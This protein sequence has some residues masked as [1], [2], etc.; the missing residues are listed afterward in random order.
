MRNNSDP[1]DVQPSSFQ[2]D[3]L[4]LNLHLE[5]KEI[6]SEPQRIVHENALAQ[7]RA[8]ASRS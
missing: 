5:E 4:N 6:A 3:L 1:R 8:L 7:M 2:V